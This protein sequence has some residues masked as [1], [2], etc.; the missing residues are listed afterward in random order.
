MSAKLLNVYVDMYV[1]LDTDPQSVFF[2]EKSALSLVIGYS[3]GLSLLCI[4]L[5]CLLCGDLHT[6]IRDQFQKRYYAAD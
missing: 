6:A 1:Y 3:I 5:I 2:M 4:E